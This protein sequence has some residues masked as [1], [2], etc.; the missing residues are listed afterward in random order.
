MR[1]TRGLSLDT[2]RCNLVRSVLEGIDLWAAEVVTA[3]AR[4]IAL[5]DGISIDGGMTRNPR[6]QVMSLVR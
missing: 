2:S 4:H 5:D 1:V 6:L 3:K